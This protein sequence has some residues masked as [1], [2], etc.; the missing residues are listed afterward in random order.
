M[1]NPKAEIGFFKIEALIL[2]DTY[3]PQFP[4]RVNNNGNKIIIFPSG[5]FITYVTLHELLASNPQSYNILESR[6]FIPNSNYK[7][8]KDVIH[9]TYNKRLEL[10]AS[11]NPAQLPVKIILN[12]IYGKFGQNVNKVIGNLFN[13]ALLSFITGFTRT[14]MYKF[15]RDNNLN[16]EVVSFATDSICLTKKLNLPETKELDK[17]FLS[18]PTDDVFILQ[19]GFYRFNGIWTSR[20]FGKDAGKEVEHVDTKE[21]DGRLYIILQETRTIR[22]RTGI[23]EKRINDIGRFYTKTKQVN[24]NADRKRYWFTRL[25]S[26]NEKV[27]CE[28]LPISL[29]YFTQKHI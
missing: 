11:N 8:F 7:P 9:E 13:P 17:F 19:N 2:N 21:I 12:S 5:N 24:L 22:L 15:V 16:K 6:Q 23:L 18:K 4:F 20:G 26:I 10:K 14:Q 28:S 1:I 3:I 27:F 25:E 29:N